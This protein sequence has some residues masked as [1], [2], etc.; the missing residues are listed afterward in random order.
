MIEASIDIGTNTV[1]L[2]V[3]EKRDGRLDVLHEEQ[4][5]PRL[6]KQADSDK[7][8]NRES[9]DRVIR[10]LTE[11]ATL[12]RERFP[13][14][15]KPPVVT[16]TSAVRD[17]PNRALFLNAAEEATE[18]KVRVLSGEE[19]SQTTYRG[20]LS[21][22]D[23]EIVKG[24]RTLILDIG[25]GSTEFALGQEGKLL[26]AQSL[27]MGSVRFTER[28]FSCLPPAEDE[29]AE[30]ARAVRN[31]L[32]N[33]KGD[34]VLKG[35]QSSPAGGGQEKHLLMVGVAGTVTSIAALSAGLTQ[36]E[37]DRLNG[38][39]LPLS[40]IRKYRNLFE[41]LSPSVIE[42]TFAPFLVG[43]GEV[44]TAGLIILEEVM[45]FYNKKVLTVSTGG[46]RHGMLI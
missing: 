42:E 46:V 36:Y 37:T 32:R 11:F 24:R 3:A 30:V 19:E 6:G 31:L 39:K 27:D 9:M 1:L 33:L 44:I 14:L 12:L 5:L 40:E 43:R 41:S 4:R 18:W 2:L 25:G 23:P 38:M 21:V 26:A 35:D 13:D 7:N 28:Y 29:K 34:L 17:A 8:L 16:A 15:P 22:L 45:R 10:S 20:A